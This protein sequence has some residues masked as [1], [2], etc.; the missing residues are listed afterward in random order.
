MKKHAQPKIFGLIKKGAAYLL[1]AELVAFGG[2]YYVYHRMNTER[3]FRYYMH[4]NY[5]FALESFYTVGE[6]FQPANQTRL[7]D[8]AIWSKQHPCCDSLESPENQKGY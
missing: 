4:K 1:A 3:D 5:N 8:E 7:L 6:Y 2:A